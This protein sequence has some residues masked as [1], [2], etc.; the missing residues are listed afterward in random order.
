MTL[1]TTKYRR[2]LNA[3]IPDLAARILAD[4]DDYGAAAAALTTATAQLGADV[5][6]TPSNTYVDV[7]S[8]GSLAAGTW[9]VFGAFDVI[10]SA[11]S[12]TFKLWDGSTVYDASEVTNEGSAALRSVAF[13]SPPI[14]LAAP[15]TIKVSGATNV[16]GAM[17]VKAAA[18]LNNTGIGNKVSTLTAIKIA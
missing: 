1:D 7:L 16:G 11:C 15:A 12:G 3:G 14:V 6:L 5:N 10:A 9:I 4:S 17:Q 8:L 2:L 13:V 18:V